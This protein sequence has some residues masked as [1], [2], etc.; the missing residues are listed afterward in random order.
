M[1]L[2]TSGYYHCAVS[3]DVIRF[4]RKDN[5]EWMEW[6]GAGWEK[7]GTWSIVQYP[8]KR[9]FTFTY[10]YTREEM[11][12]ISNQTLCEIFPHGDTTPVII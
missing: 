10:N 7:L 1:L 4:F 6:K 2:F 8:E 5:E 11:G 9:V 12:R 3:G